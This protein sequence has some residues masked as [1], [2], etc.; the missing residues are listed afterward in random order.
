MGVGLGDCH[1][2]QWP[3]ERVWVTAAAAAR[4]AQLALW[5]G[6]AVALALRALGALLPISA[7]FQGQATRS[8]GDRAAD[9]RLVVGLAGPVPAR[10]ARL[11]THWPAV[12]A[13][14]IAPF[15]VGVVFLRPPILPTSA[16]EIT[17]GASVDVLR[18]Q[19]I[20]VD[21]NPRPKPGPL[22]TPWNRAF[23]D[24]LSGNG[25]GA[26]EVRGWPVETRS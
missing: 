12:L 22:R 20:T 18:G 1:A 15:V 21:D 2:W 10:Y 11:A 8:D 6:L 23:P 9:A 26:G 24:H 16:L 3:C 4:P 14:V 13:A 5:A 25:A 17:T 19:V 7:R